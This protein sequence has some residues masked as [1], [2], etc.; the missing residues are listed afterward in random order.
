MG[1]TRKYG[2]YMGAM[3]ARWQS[4]E[5]NNCKRLKHHSTDKITPR[6]NQA[7]CTK[8]E[9][10]NSECLTRMNPVTLQGSL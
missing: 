6:E 10:L 3:W 4:T 8:P 9:E 7:I 5:N 1:P 2:S